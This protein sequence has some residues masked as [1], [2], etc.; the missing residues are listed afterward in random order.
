MDW[1][2]PMARLTRK[3]IRK[4]IGKMVRVDPGHTKQHGSRCGNGSKQHKIPAR[5]LRVRKDRALVHPLR[6]GRTEW[7]PLS[8]CHSWIGGNHPLT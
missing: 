3:T 5:L 7:V 4:Y 1:M 6:H 2:S 8:A